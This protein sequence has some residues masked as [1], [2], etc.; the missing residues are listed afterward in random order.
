MKALFDKDET[1]FA[2]VWIVIYVVGFG[3][4]GVLTDDVVTNYAA[5]VAVGLVMV[6]ALVTFASKNGLLE[7]WGLC[8]LRGDARRFLW[9]VPLVVFMSENVWLGLGTGEDSALA[10]VL[11][12]AA[13]G[14]LAPILEELVLRVILYRALGHSNAL[15]AF[16]ICSVTFGI[17][18]IVN[19][20]FGQDPVRTLTQVGYALCIGF[21]FM[22]VLH[23]GRSVVPISLAHI[24]MNTLS[25]FANQG[26]MGTAADYATI[27]IMC[28]GC[29][30]YG[31][32]VLRAHA[33]ER[34][35]TNAPLEW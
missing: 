29:V 32:Y 25:F 27:A 16:V 7:Y 35:L 33:G 1:I 26:E 20:L 12:I 21:C 3:N 24:E 14:V 10:T 6:V 23:A 22:A 8:P 19:L 15:R 9:F 5:Q 2:A 31:I 18:H 11:G 4:A 30:A 13:I 34:P 17:G 28:V